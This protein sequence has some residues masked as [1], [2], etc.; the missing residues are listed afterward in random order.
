MSEELVL[1]L[2][3]QA[4]ELL[5]VV[6][7]P[8]LIVGLV[9]GVLVSVFQIVTSIQ[10]STLS[11]VPRLLAV[12]I[13]FLLVFPWMMNLVTDFTVTLMSSIPNYIR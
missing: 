10:D 2:A 12:F 3:K 8:M 11:F 9:V 6:S 5:L 7:A 4:I 1:T 13:S